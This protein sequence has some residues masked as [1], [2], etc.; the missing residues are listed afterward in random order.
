MSNYLKRL[1]LISPTIRTFTSKL[2]TDDYTTKNQR[3]A[4]WDVQ[5]SNTG[6]NQLGWA[7]R[8]GSHNVSLDGNITHK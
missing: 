6:K 1:G 3:S 5:L 7:T 2:D 8:D 4:I